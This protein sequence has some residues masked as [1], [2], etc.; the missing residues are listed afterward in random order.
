MMPSLCSRL[1]AALLLVLCW[2][3]TPARAGDVEDCASAAADKVEPACTAIIND[4]SKP[5]EDRLKALLNRSRLF[6][7]RLKLD[8]ALTDAEAAVLLNPK[9]VSALLQRGYAKQRKGNFEG[10]LADFNQAIELEPRNAIAWFNRGNLRNIQRNFADALAD[11]SQ[12]ITLRPDYAQAYA[13]R[14][15]PISRTARSIRQWPIS[16]GRSRST[17][18]R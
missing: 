6:A 8:L 10:A 13:S 5:A 2:T 14:G 18:V 3:Q 1:P 9:S 15:S 12:A 16:T 11:L 4:A 7:A 17:Q